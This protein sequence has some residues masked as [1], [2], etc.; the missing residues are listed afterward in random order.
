MTSGIQTY[1]DQAISDVEKLIV[2][3]VDQAKGLY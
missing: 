1:L 3:P 2:I